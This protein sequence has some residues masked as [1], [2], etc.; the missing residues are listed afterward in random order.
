MSAIFAA[1]VFGGILGLYSLIEDIL[2]ACK[3]RRP[4]AKPLSGR[5]LRRRYK[6]R[7]HSVCRLERESASY[8]RQQRE[9]L[10]WSDR[11]VGRD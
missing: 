8:A 3:S 2:W 10:R 4:M 7:L 11:L 5:Q 9:L 6:T 1:A